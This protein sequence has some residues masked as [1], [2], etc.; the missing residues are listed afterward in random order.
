MGTGKLDG[1]K[2]TSTKEHIFIISR[3]TSLPLK[4]MDVKLCLLLLIAIVSI[5]AYPR[6]RRIPRSMYYVDDYD[7]GYDSPRWVDLAPRFPL[8]PFGFPGGSRYYDDDDYHYDDPQPRVRPM[9][10][11]GRYRFGTDFS[12]NANLERRRQQTRE[13][14]Q[15]HA[16]EATTTTTRRPTPSYPPERI[17]PKDLDWTS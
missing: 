12:S 7:Y 10:P 9:R 17:D 1:V 6:T 5:A 15:R 2:S 11:Y 13:T 4:D 16:Y 14:L 3:Q 8:A